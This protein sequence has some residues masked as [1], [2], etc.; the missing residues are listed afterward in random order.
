VQLLQ[1]TLPV[2]EICGGGKSARE[3]GERER[4]SQR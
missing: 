2:V 1:L 4:E 3:G